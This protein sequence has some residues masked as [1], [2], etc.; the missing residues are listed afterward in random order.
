MKTH[1]K[2]QTERCK[3]EE[4]GERKLLFTKLALMSENS[5]YHKSCIACSSWVS[6]EANKVHNESVDMHSNT[7]L[8]ILEETQFYRHM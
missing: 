8:R 5:H 3:Q 1:K 6:A 2:K 4:E 7:P